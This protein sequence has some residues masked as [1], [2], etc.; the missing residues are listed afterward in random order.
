MSDRYQALHDLELAFRRW[1][2]AIGVDAPDVGIVVISIS[3]EG[4]DLQYLGIEPR[5]VVD[6][7]NLFQRISE[8]IAA[9]EYT[10]DDST[11]VEFH[12][13]W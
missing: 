2:R 8:A 6:W 9:G 12:R 7:P 13:R 10:I 1:Y 3:R 11:S 5:A 4:S